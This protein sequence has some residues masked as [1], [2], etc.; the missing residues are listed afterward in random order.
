[1]KSKVSLSRRKYRIRH[2]SLIARE[3]DFALDVSARDDIIVVSYLMIAAIVPSCNV[4]P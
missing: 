1:M 2:S 4:G 3:I